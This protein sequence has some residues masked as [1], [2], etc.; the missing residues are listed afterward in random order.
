MTETL[1]AIEFVHL[2]LAEKICIAKKGVTSLSG[3]SILN[4]HVCLATFKETNR[5]AKNVLFTTHN[6]WSI[7]RTI[8]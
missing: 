6:L 5:I 1:S 4:M 8:S 3:Q 7:H 2:K